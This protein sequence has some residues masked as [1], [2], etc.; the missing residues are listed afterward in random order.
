MDSLLSEETPADT[1]DA[2]GEESAKPNFGQSDNSD[3][4]PTQGAIN[5]GFDDK[6]EAADDK[7]EKEEVGEN[8]PFQFM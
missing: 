3:A 4:D 1:D 5:M 6:D 8:P 7:K 2:G